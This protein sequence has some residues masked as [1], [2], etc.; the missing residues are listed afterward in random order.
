MDIR[1][2]KQE[3][4]MEEVKRAVQKLMEKTENQDLF[5]HKQVK[6]KLETGHKVLGVNFEDDEGGTYVAAVREQSNRNETKGKGIP[7]KPVMSNESRGYV[8]KGHEDGCHICRDPGHWKNDCPVGKGWAHNR[9][10]SEPRPEMSPIENHGNHASGS[11][12]PRAMV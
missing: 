3:F 7:N 10:R 5:L 1:V 12:N 9:S 8:A 11:Q 6:S 2:R 4:G